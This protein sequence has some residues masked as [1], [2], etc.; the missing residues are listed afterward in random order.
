MYHKSMLSI[1]IVGVAI[2]PAAC[3]PQPSGMASPAPASSLS[4]PANAA[5]MTT[6]MPNMA[7]MDHSSMP[8]MKMPGMDHSSMPGMKMP[9]MDATS[10][11]G[12]DHSNMPS[13]QGMDMNA[14]MTQCAQ[15]RQQS[16]SGQTASGRQMLDQCDQM[17]R[18]M[19][20]TPSPRR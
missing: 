18:S 4:G 8:G 16:T 9:G 7:G 12:M 11:P 6:P 2:L 19:G 1:L 13:M 17:D 14:M 5:A 15:T 10:M 20:M 3:A